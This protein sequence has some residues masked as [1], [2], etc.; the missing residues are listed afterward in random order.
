MNRLVLIG[1]GFDLAHGMKTSYNDFMTDYLR[2]AFRGV[3]NGNN[4]N[5]E[6]ISVFYDRSG[7]KL[8]MNGNEVDSWNLNDFI[9]HLTSSTRNELRVSMKAKS[10][11]AEY[12]FK[13]CKKFNWVDIENVYY[14]LLCDLTSKNK[15]SDIQQLNQDLEF[16]KTLLK[17]YLLKVEKHFVENDADE[18][19][20][21]DFVEQITNISTLSVQERKNLRIEGI[22]EKPESILFLNFNYTDTIH[23]YIPKI[24]EIISSCEVINIHGKLNKDDNPIIFGYGDESETNFGLLEK[25]DECLTYVKTYWYSRTNNYRKF[26]D[27]VN[28]GNFD[29]YVLGHSCGLSDKTLLSEVF[30]NENCRKIKL[31]TYLKDPSRPSAIDN[32]DYISKTYQIGRIFEN[33]GEM[34]NKL[35]PYSPADVLRLRRRN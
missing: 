34:R 32:T 1:N 16:L 24:N 10:K 27:F 5:D 25:Y 26:L 13:H 6:L 19:F 2:E 28:C 18:F 15:L 9:N 20:R 35:I 23:E 4:F 33:K 31:L 29:V 21:S 8:V 3:F 7:W 17:N 22:S 11:F 30:N 14:D 12:L